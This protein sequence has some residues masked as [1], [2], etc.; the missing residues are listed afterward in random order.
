MCGSG[1]GVK[2]RRLGYV[3]KAVVQK[4]D[5]STARHV[6]FIAEMSC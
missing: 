4:V 1:G 5:P 6:C 3:F 2:R